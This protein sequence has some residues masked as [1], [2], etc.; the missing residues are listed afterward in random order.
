MKKVTLENVKGIRKL[1]FILPQKH[2]VYLVTGKN[3]TGKT[4]LLVALY[5]IC[6]SDAFRNYFASGANNIDDVDNYKITYENKGSKVTYSHT[7][8]GWDPHPRNTN[9]LISFGYSDTIYVSA[10][11]MRFEVHAPSQLK[12]RRL[13]KHN[14]S[15]TFKDAM[16]KILGTSKFNNLKYIQIVNQGRPGHRIRH[17]NKLYIVDG[18]NY[19]E[20]TFSLGERFVLNMLDQLEGVSNNT[21]VVIDEMKLALHP[22]AQIAFYNY[23]KELAN[24]KNLTI[25]IATHSPSLIK[26]SDAVYYLEDNGGDITVLDKCKPSYILSGLTDYVD[27]NFDKIFIVEDK[28]AYYCLDTILKE[29]FRGIQQ[30]LNYK[31]VF[32]GGWSQVIEFLKQMNTILPYKDDMV[33]AYLDL[34]AKTSLEN[35]KSSS[36]LNEG[37]QKDLNNYNDVKKYI[38]FLHITPEI[39]MWEWLVDNEG[40]FLEQWRKKSNNVLFSLKDTINNIDSI[41]NHSRSSNSCKECFKKL[42]AQLISTPDF[43]DEICRKTIVEIYYECA[44][45]PNSIW[46]NINQTLFY[47]LNM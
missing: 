11:K 46:E 16:N 5:R 35:L 41:H 13:C 33:F 38:S 28:M 39:G 7:Q 30:L 45:F 17:N 24:V 43:P 27:N 47:Q 21:L 14:V 37:Q 6:N 2:G 10:T 9:V 26:R 12:Q 3:G 25:I 31:I 40:L 42:L 20:N 23:L 19:S 29:H 8:H 32:V 44:V 4:N 22:I 36:N 15:Q 1:D 34:D 18:L